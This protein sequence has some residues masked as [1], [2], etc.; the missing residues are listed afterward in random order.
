MQVEIIAADFENEVHASSI[1]AILDSYASDP[2]GGAEPLSADVRR[3]LIPALRDH[4][5]SLV[6]LALADGAAVGVAVCFIGISTFQ[7]RP[8]LNL[9][10]L[11]VLPEW[12][13]RGIGSSLLTAAERYAERHGYCKL[14]LEVQETNEPAVRLYRRFGFTDLT[15]GDSGPTR[16][17]TKSL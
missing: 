7:A 3:R 5:T 15:M 16:F 8:L 6:L 13:G 4:P 17:M 12:R 10:D 11:A 2:V 9:H 14:T 1:V